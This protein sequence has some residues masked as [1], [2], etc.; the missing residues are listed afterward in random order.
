[1]IDFYFWTTPN[2]Y[3]ILMFLEETGVPYRI[4][5][6]N[7][8]K[9]EQFEPEF[10]QISPNNKMPAIIDHSPAD[11]GVP[12]SLFESGAILSDRHYNLPSV[13]SAQEGFSNSGLYAV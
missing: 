6:V 1:M 3:K 10:M 13:R 7:I 9:G 2:G 11:P 12:I 4:V 5:P 8:S